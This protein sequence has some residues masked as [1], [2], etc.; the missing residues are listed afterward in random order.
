MTNP[1][2]PELVKMLACL[3]LHITIETSGIKF[4]P[5]LPCDLMSISPKLSNST[6]TEA[7]LAAQHE[8]QRFDLPALQQLID[9][10]KYQLKFVVDQAEDLK[11]ITR[12]LEQLKN[13]EP[14][15]VFLMPQAVTV[16][17]YLA[18]SRMV[19]E[20]CKQ[21]GFRFSPRLQVALWN[22]QK[23]M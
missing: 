12:C 22:G 20:L 9:G 3:G 1:E 4:V 11:E 18:K 19:A 6:P 17:E 23:G 10:Y 7:E 8:K 5:D 2:L 13:A 14:D 16:D 15:K 21:T